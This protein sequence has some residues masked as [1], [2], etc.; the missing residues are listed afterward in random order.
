MGRHGCTCFAPCFH[1]MDGVVVY[2]LFKPD[3][4]L[5]NIFEAGFIKYFRFKTRQKIFYDMVRQGRGVS[6]EVTGTIERTIS[7]IVLI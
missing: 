1:L 2:L 6:L 3:K 5:L 4:R 7:P